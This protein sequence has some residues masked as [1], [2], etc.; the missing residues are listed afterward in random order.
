[1]SESLF[2]PPLRLAENDEIVGK[3]HQFDPAFLDLLVQS[4]KVKIGQ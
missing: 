2:R 1:M 3:P 4:I